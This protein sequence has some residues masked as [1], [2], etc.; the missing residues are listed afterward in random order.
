MIRTVVI[1][2]VLDDKFV[3]GLVGLVQLIY[4]GNILFG[5]R[6]ALGMHVAVLSVG[7]MFMRYFFTARCTIVQSAVLRVHVVCPS[8][9]LS[10]RL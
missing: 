8:V 1:F 6:C 7:I 3:G 5:A 10:V 2:D 9:R 4:C